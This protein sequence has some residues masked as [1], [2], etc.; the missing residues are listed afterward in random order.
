VVGEGAILLVEDA[1]SV[2]RVVRRILDKAG[3]TV[4]EAGNGC[5]A[6]E[7]LEG[8]RETSGRFDLVLTDAVMPGLG[9]A[10]LVRRLRRDRPDLGVLLMSG[11]PLDDPRRTQ[12]DLAGA[13]FLQKPFGSCELLARVREVLDARAVIALRKASRPRYSRLASSTA[14]FMS[15]THPGTTRT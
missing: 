3:Y 15:S 5:E 2:R 11:Y 10:K 13:A 9:G 1:R 8:A 14:R 7:V 4:V 6:L 12:D